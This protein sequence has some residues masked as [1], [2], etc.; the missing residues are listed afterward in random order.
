MSHQLEILF[1]YDDE[2]DKNAACPKLDL[3]DGLSTVRDLAHRNLRERNSEI[4][5]QPNRKLDRRKSLDQAEN[6]SD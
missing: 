3:L 5:N 6:H 1:D 2:H 4:S